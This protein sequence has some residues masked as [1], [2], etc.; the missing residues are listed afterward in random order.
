MW[1]LMHFFSYDLYCQGYIIESMKSTRV[2]KLSICLTWD[3]FFEWHAY[4][5]LK[6][7]N[8]MYMYEACTYAL[9]GN[10]GR[11]WMSLLEKTH[12]R[13][14]NRRLYDS[15]II[16]YLRNTFLLFNT[17]VGLYHCMH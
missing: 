13:N 4:F 14:P 2:I 12:I 1:D 10:S 3:E 17:H 16:H 6:Q 5:L 11:T 7:Q 15:P 9:V 8:L